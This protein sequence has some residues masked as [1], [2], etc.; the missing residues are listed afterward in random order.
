[1]HSD[2]IKEIVSILSCHSPQFKLEA[3]SDGSHKTLLQITTNGLVTHSFGSLVNHSNI[4]FSC[5]SSSSGRNG[6]C[7]NSRSNTATT[8]NSRSSSSENKSG[9]KESSFS[10][11]KSGRN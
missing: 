8:S 7:N 2:T 1:M 4:D 10:I 5:I 9:S 11:Y 6:S 3:V